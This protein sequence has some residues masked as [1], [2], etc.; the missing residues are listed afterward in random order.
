MG[1]SK[2][3]NESVLAPIDYYDNNVAGTLS[4]LKAMQ[5]SNVKT[6]VFSSSASVYGASKYNPIDEGHSLEPVS[7]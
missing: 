2:S 6:L 4:L 7:S 5:S 3:V 1:G